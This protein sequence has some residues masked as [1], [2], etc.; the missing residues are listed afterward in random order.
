MDEKTQSI[1]L[2]AGTFSPVE[3]AHVLFSFIT[4]KI[5]F[6][7]LQLLNIAELSNDDVIHSEQRIKALKEAKSLAKDLILKARNQG[8]E[9]KIDSTIEIKLI[10]TNAFS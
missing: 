9:L 5:K 8:Y 7:N 2:V 4:D 10:K 3:A 6:H 1:Q